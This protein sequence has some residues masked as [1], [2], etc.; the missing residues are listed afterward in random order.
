[1]GDPGTYRAWR[2][3]MLSQLI[4]QPGRV[5]II[6]IAIALGVA[7]GT[8]V[9]LVNGAALNEFGLATKRLVGEADIIVRGGQLEF[10]E[11]LFVRLARDPA[12]AL[13]SPQL[14]LQVALAERTDTLKIMGL[15]PFRAAALQP[16]LLGDMSTSLF[17]LFEE[18]GIYLSASAAAQLKLHAGDRLAVRVG[19]SSKSVP[20]IGVLTQGSYPERL[21]IMDIAT[22]QWLFNDLGRL[23][24]IDLQLK[25]GSDVD[26]VRRRLAA[27]LPAGVQAVAPEVERARALSVT[28]AY[29]V[30]LNM[31]ALVALWTGA[32]L[33]YTTLS[34]AVLR[35]GRIIALLRALGVSA[36]QVQ[37]ALLGEGVVLG[38]AG[39]L[40]GLLL[41]AALAGVILRVFA[42]D[43]GSGQLRAVAE[44]LR[45]SPLA[46]T[47][48]ALLGVC[49]A[50]AG[51]FFP[52]RGAAR[53]PPASALKGGNLDR[54]ASAALGWRS[55]VSLLALGIALALA[56]AV[57]GLA[58]FGYAAVGSLLLGAVLLV[59][60]LT[61]L[62]LRLA[63]HTR[64]TAFN[65]AIAQL[66]GNVAH[67][68]LSL[69]SIIV[70]FSL[71]VAMAIMVYS[72]R[73]SFDSWLGKLL[74]ADLQLRLPFDN[75]T[76]YWT[77]AEQDRIAHL[78]GVRRAE[79]RRTRRIL[80]DPVRAPV[81]LIA[82]GST[83]A[84]AAGQL[85]LLSSAPSQLAPPNIPIWVSEAFQDLYGAKVGEPLTLPLPGHPRAVVAG[86]WR[87]YVRPGGA[88]V[89]TR[90]EFAR[91]T[92]DANATEGSLWLDPGADV[93]A[94]EAAVR[95]GANAGTLEII[96][97]AALKERSLQIFDRA[98][99][100]TYALEAVAVL[101]GL[102]GIS[103]AASS[104][105]LARRAEFGMLRHIG[106]L[107]RDV[108][109]MLASEG[110]LT[111]IIGVLYGLILGVA[112]SV[113]LVY[114][115]NRQSFNWSIDLALPAR[116]MMALS[117]LLIA[118]AALTALL[119]GRA[120]LSQDAVRAVRE[121]W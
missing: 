39:A 111:S 112:L 106:L 5:L 84:E 73:L 51:S 13:A 50:T 35:R 28:R 93:A 53:T 74:P 86:V 34:L 96:S 32:F 36:R 22:A 61:A 43:L 94:L 29:R 89:M 14:E 41:G 83:S 101:I 121:D 1:L 25:P 107:R 114:V 102:L 15:D 77:P 18:G 9:Y 37:T 24:R 75:D 46:M 45:A 16:A 7:L 68:S 104:T 85:P 3:L 65:T 23:N 11:Q 113:V 95:Q 56:P 117:T 87:D 42:G 58:L 99:I 81:T 33:V 64:F 19:N 80:M 110:F 118:A 67:S 63:P 52:A 26:A 10:D 119:S 30:N 97:S 105:A 90:G 17:K 59:P 48:F 54:S 79:F 82:R 60:V 120:A 108:L 27:N 38:A 62:L 31:L 72:F 109:L 78:D 47:A 44:T 8:A 4:E 6:V 103:F 69:A 20:V 2:I 88:I 21:G 76:A 91:I 71:M 57:H 92:E 70:S 12:V 98:F 66:R 55:G 49:A 40:L 116:Q 115:V 100:V